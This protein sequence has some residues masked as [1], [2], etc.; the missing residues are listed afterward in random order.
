MI[1]ADSAED[2]RL[3]FL[4]VEYLHE[5]NQRNRRKDMTHRYFRR[6]QPLGFR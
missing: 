4:G 2:A 1:K 6:I 3:M 5:E